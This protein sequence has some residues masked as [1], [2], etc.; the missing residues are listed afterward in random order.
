MT[1]GTILYIN[2]S[3][4]IEAHY[5]LGPDEIFHSLAHWFFITILWVRYKCYPYF[6]N[7]K[8]K[9]KRG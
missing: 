1:F 5:G 3:D 6:P 4:N 9:A 2:V 8:T 7:G